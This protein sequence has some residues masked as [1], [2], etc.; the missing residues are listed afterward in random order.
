MLYCCHKLTLDEKIH[1]PA[2]FI[3]NTVGH[4]AP[5]WPLIITGHNDDSE[6]GASITELN[7]G[8]FCN[9]RAVIQSEGREGGSRGG[10]GQSD[11]TAELQQNFVV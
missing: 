1:W 7:S 3:T 9:L 11:R 10:A 5:E 2:D 6:S 8:T 4:I